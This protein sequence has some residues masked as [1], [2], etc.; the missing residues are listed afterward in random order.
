VCFE[1][2]A[3]WRGET[4]EEEGELKLKVAEREETIAAAIK[5]NKD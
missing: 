5:E 1:L 4:K 2:L 3:R